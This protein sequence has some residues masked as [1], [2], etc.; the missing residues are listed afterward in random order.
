MY[1]KLLPV[2]FLF[3]L[4]FQ[5]AKTQQESQFTQ[6]MHN[7]QFFNPAYVGIK[8]TPEIYGLYRQQ[9]IGYGGG[10]QTK[11]LGFNSSF[12]S[13]RNGIGLLYSSQSIGITKIWTGKVSY[14]YQINTGE[15]SALRLG[16][17][18]NMK[19][20]QVDFKDPGIL[21]LENQDPVIL[22]GQVSTQHQVN[23]GAGMYFLHPKGF[24]GFSVPNMLT[25][26][27]GWTKNIGNQQTAIEIPHFYLLA[28]F[29]HPIGE[30]LGLKAN[31][32]GKF[33][34]NAPLDLDLN[35]SLTFH[36]SISGGISYRFG[37]AGLGES[38]DLML[39]YRIKNL[40]LGIAYDLLLSELTNS[41]SG[42]F[43]ILCRY[44]LKKSSNPPQNPKYG[45]F[46]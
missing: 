16:L 17:S 41:S 45:H 44:H 40:D 42:S 4:S 38:L 33:V 25:R 31:V 14:A 6:F 5:I 30:N 34:K 35:F 19:Q 10:P 43:E 21:P 26:E 32:L 8:E 39:L 2:F 46:F 37:G 20:F 18:G 15:K 28:G 7:Q 1:K 13:P 24:L 9:W 27:I 11:V 23:W 3:L 36:Q 22:A 29:F 12:L